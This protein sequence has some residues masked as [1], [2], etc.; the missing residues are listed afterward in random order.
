MFMISMYL[1]LINM[2][3]TQI[4]LYAERNLLAEEIS[5][6]KRAEEE[7]AVLESQL[8]Q[9]QKSESLDRMAGAIAHHFNNQLHAVI[10]NL[11]LALEQ[12]PQDTASSYYLAEAMQAS[13]RASSVSNL[14]LTYIGQTPS[15]RE[16]LDLS[17]TC[18]AN[19]PIL[20]SVVP[21]SVELITNLSVPDLIVNANENQIQQVLLNLLT[22]AWE[23][24]DD[25][26]CTIRLSAM[27]ASPS[28]ISATHRFPIDARLQN[29][30]YACLE[31]ADSGSGIA[32]GKMG[33]L[34]D[35]F[36]STKFTGRGMGLAVVLGIVRAHEG[37][38]AVESEPGKGS[39][40]RVYIPLTS[41]VVVRPP[42]Q[43]A[44]PREILGS[45]VFLLVDDEEPIRKI[46]SLM[47]KHLGYTVLTA[48]DGVEAVEVFRQHEQEIRCVLCDL[49]M[50]RM[51][52]WETLTALRQIAPG[53]P[54]IMA[55]GYGA[56][57]LL[58]K[59]SAQMPNATLTKPYLL[60]ELCEAVRKAL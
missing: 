51:D 17:E 54:V 21:K 32:A 4:I 13:R 22:N 48:K 40:F 3:R 39:V 6:R 28:D 31:V 20:Q 9:A 11:D 30:P 46:G 24:Q 1:A 53:L 38:I 33:S 10:G 14:M 47:L 2:A 29:K 23:A 42:E 7:K 41:E 59:D 60:D 12:L 19:L 15:K 52:G 49:T 5:E 36:F 35:P 18:R 16:P 58:A 25:G 8:W 50:P 56:D 45:G 44:E 55:T 37:V 57:K 34:F 27:A 43:V 26:E